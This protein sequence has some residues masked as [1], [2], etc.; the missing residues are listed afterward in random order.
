MGGVIGL[1]GCFLT[2]LELILLFGFHGNK[3]AVSQAFFECFYLPGL[4]ASLYIGANNLFLLNRG[5]I[6]HMGQILD[7]LAV[8]AFERR[9]RAYI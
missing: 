2:W 1:R 9:E 5:S 3:P 8:F 7:G 6:I 4:F